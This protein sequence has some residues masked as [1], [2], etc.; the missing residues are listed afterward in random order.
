VRHL[1]FDFFGT[2]VSYDERVGHRV[3]R[4]QRELARRGV[5]VGADALAAQLADCV[6]TLDGAAQTTLVEFSMA[7][8][9]RS[10][11]GELGLAPTDATVSDFVDAF[12]S[13][14]T[15]GVAPLPRLH[16]WLAALPM[17][18]SVLSNTHHE[19]MVL[20]LI[21]RF[22]LRDAFRHVT[23]SIG[24]GMRKPHASVYRAHLE[25]IGVAAQDAV[26]VGD[27]PQ[28]DYFGPR[29]VGIEAYLIAPRPVPG[30]PERRR[31]AHLY[32]LTE[33]LDG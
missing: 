2:L 27:N 15:G 28:C 30:V 10:L 17:P 13:D 14:W 6:A 20:G 26:F 9:V 8:A 18:K 22:G 25:A 12:L 16:E 7:E 19:P 29:A 23:T 32:Q 1:I 31:L 11:Y 33:R 21:E 4:A 3:E 24:H 5:D